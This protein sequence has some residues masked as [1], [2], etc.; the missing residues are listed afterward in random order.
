[1]I[2]VRQISP[3]RKDAS[4]QDKIAIF[5]FYLDKKE[6]GDLSSEK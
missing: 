6:F 4:V 2:L 5:T 1:M 3:N